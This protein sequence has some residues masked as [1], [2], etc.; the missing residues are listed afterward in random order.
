MKKTDGIA[1]FYVELD[2]NINTMDGS[3]MLQQLSSMCDRL[4]LVGAYTS[5]VYK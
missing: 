4:K 1:N 2:G 3:D 5:R